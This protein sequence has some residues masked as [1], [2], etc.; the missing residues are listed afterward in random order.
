MYR[1]KKITHFRQAIIAMSD[2]G[3]VD[4]YEHHVVTRHPD[5]PGYP[6]PADI[7]LYKLK[8]QGMSWEREIK[9]DVDWK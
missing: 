4:G 2:F 7:D 6:G 1:N 8:K 3:S 5:T 9:S